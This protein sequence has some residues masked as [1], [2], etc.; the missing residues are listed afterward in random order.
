LFVY[1]EVTQIIT[2]TILHKDTDFGVKHL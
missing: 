2:R 1:S